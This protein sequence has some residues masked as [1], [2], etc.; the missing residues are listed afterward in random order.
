MSYSLVQSTNQAV[1]TSPVSVTFTDIPN[2]GNLI[3]ASIGERGS[4]AALSSVQDGNGNSLTLLNSK[5]GGG[6]YYIYLYGMIAFA[7][8]SKTMTVTAS[9]V[10]LSINIYELSG[11]ASSIGGIIDNSQAMGTNGST[12]TTS[13]SGSQPSVTTTNPDDLLFTQVLA[14][15]NVSSTAW[16]TGGGAPIGMLQVNTSGAIRMFDGY[17]FETTAGSFNPYG[18]WTPPETWVQLT[19]VLLPSAASSESGLMAV[20][21]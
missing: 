12:A 15:S 2:Q 8:Q 20:F 13:T 5:V 10:A 3:L 7:S 14:G 19:T 1:G 21:M 4:T 11:N 18:S 6:N 17:A 9:G 16:T